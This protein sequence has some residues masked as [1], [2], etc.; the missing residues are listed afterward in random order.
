MKCDKLY[1]KKGDDLHR[2]TT[3]IIKEVIKIIDKK[4]DNENDKINVL[5]A[6]ASIIITYAVDNMTSGDISL[7]MEML[8][9]NVSNNTKTKKIIFKNSV[10]FVKRS[11]EQTH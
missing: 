11:E 1:M 5:N 8:F 3:E 9:D 10:T 6:V 4:I 7:F 2:T